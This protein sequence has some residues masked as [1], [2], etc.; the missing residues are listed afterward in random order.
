MRSLAAILVAVLLFTPVESYAQDRFDAQTY[1]DWAA[2]AN[3]LPCETQLDGFY[4]CSRATDGLYPAAALASQASGDVLLTFDTSYVDGALSIENARVFSSSPEGLFDVAALAIAHDFRF[5]PEMRNCQGLRAILSFRVNDAN[6]D[7]VMRGFVVPAYANAPLR[8]DTT[9]ALREGSLRD[10]CG[11]EDGAI[12][13]E[14]FG[15]A[16]AALYPERAS[17]RGHDGWAVVQ[18]T[19]APDGSVQG[20]TVLEESQGG[21]EFG[22]AALQAILVARY[23]RRETACV[24]AASTVRFVLR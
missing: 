4:P 24:N 14:E 12:N 10:H 22:A 2:A 11:I 23:P 7:R 3:G 18:Y 19:I 16:L 1:R 13:K 9:R 21:F 8:A 20:P 5:P 17:M 6:A 15:I